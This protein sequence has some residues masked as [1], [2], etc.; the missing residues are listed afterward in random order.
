MSP[1]LDVNSQRQGLCLSAARPPRGQ[2]G[3]AVC[4]ARMK[5]EGSAGPRDLGE[6]SKGI[7]RRLTSHRGLSRGRMGER[8][9]HLTWSQANPPQPPATLRP[10]ASTCPG[11]WP[12]ETKIHLLPEEARASSLRGSRLAPPPPGSGDQWRGVGH[13]PSLPEIRGPWIDPHVSL[14]P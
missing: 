4:S 2:C 11:Q 3:E 1:R 5:M 10:S 7:K 13:L 12:K 9:K 14:Q 6:S 8:G